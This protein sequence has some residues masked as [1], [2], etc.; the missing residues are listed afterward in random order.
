M[1]SIE[2]LVDF[3]RFALSK[4]NQTDSEIELDDLMLEWYAAR[5]RDQIDKVIQEGLGQMKEGLGKPA[6][7]VSDELRSKFGLTTE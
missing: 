1:S 3:H 4:L 2:Q 7:F 6:G 5:D